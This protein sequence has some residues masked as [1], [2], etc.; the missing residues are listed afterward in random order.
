MTPGYSISGDYSEDLRLEDGTRIRVRLVRPSDKE[1]LASGFARLSVESRRSRFFSPKS[2]LSQQEL[3]YLTELD[4]VNHFAI[5]AVSLVGRRREEGEG[6]GIARFIRSE[7]EPDVAEAAV[8]VVDHMQGRGIG[9]LLLE[10]LVVA[11]AERGVRKFRSQVLARNR[12]I[13]EMIT[14][15]FPDA[16]FMSRGPVVMAEF[17]LPERLTPQKA[18]PLRRTRLSRLLRLAAARL[19]EF[20]PVSGAFWLSGSLRGRKAQGT[21]GRM[22][23]KLKRSRKRHSDDRSQ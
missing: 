20:R 1:H 2:R 9:H 4:G 15:A 13:R 12:R 5:G 11:A 18:A 17:P 16:L 23:V 6:L 10:R 7:R 3:R 19:V 21:S 14:E 22:Q 8:V